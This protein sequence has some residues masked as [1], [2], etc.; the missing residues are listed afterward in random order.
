MGGIAVAVRE[1]AES[2]VEKHR[3]MIARQP[4]T[5]PNLG[6]YGYALLWRVPG[7]GPGAVSP[8]E[9][10]AQILS[11]AVLDMGLES[12]VGNRKAA[13]GVTRSFLDIITDVQLNPRQI[14][15]DLQDGSVIDRAG[16]D[17]LE[18][19]R[20][21]G[22]G[23]SVGGLASLKNPRLLSIANLFRV[24]T[25]K[26]K[27]PKL[28]GLLKF[29]D[30]YRELSVLALKVETM[31]SFEFH[32]DLGFDYLQG[33]FLGKPQDRKAEKLPTSKLSVLHLLAVVNNPETPVEEIE[34]Q[35][36]PNL[37]LSF[38]LLKL[39]NSSF[40][41]FS[42]QIDSVKQAVVLLG[43]YEIRKWTS[44]L[45]LTVMDDEPPAL[46]EIAILR[47]NLCEKLAEMAGLPKENYFTVGLFSA[48]DLLMKQPI[49]NLLAQL[50]L[51]K[52]V[53][54]AILEHKGV[55]GS[56]LSCALAIEDAQWSKIDFM[57]LGQD[58][59]TDAYRYAI[60]ETSTAMKQV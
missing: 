48:L 5:T 33:T 54:E 29:L 60:Q 6:V 3:V 55:L 23:L 44:M 56:A 59:F 35:I 30:Q 41:G 37:S 17:R 34:R 12:L 1:S 26:V 38:K 47:A 46:L 2:S 58:D 51:S 28:G 19:L 4:I 57:G 24:D 50:P 25:Q 42:T 27:M 7:G 36:S 13:I 53:K 31:A 10:T 52:A 43:L 39:V 16:L 18:E 11:T 8:T 20:A 40:Y 9:A 49:V 45:A 14:I 32:R 21:L 22:Y 15:L